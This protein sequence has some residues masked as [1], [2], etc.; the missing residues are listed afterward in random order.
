[1]G[2]IV[3]GCPAANAPPRFDGTSQLVVEL[4]VAYWGVDLSLLE[5]MTSGKALLLEIKSATVAVLA[6]YEW[7]QF[8]IVLRML[9]S[10]ERWSLKPWFDQV[11]EQFPHS[12]VS[13][14]PQKEV[15]VEDSHVLQKKSA[16]KMIKLIKHAESMKSATGGA[17]NAWYLFKAV[18]QCLW[19]RCL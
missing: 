7:L 18:E 4:M 12:S 2:L 17:T 5:T 11:A 19:H 1:M 6:V 9:A 3:M 8:A 14:D 15:V 16:D 13:Q 10:S